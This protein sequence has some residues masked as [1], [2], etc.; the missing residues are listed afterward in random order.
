[1]NDTAID[2]SRLQAAFTSRKWQWCFVDQ[3]ELPAD[4]ITAL[5]DRLPHIARESWPQR[6]AWGGIYVNG[7]GV[8]GNCELPLPCKIEYYEP[9]FPL[10]HAA[11]FYPGFSSQQILYHDDQLVIAFKPI[12]IP[13]LPA[14]EQAHFNF[15]AQLEEYL[16]FRIHLP[17]RLDMSACGLLIASTDSRYHAA[18]NRLYETRSIKKYYRL[19]VSPRVCWAER[20]VDLAIAKDPIHPVLRRTVESGGK[21]ALTHFSLLQHRE[22]TSLLEARPLTGRT[23]QIR[24]HAKQIGHP[25][26]GDKFYSGADASELHLA[27]VRLAFTHPVKNIP[28]DLHLPPRFLPKWAQ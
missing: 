1:V 9:S 2:I 15:K 7:R 24:V 23:H 28:I 6:F 17:A 22:E 3:D 20:E 8:N 18:I 12:G 25:L 4:L 13:S 10:E 19:E 27:C 26:V 21:S 14:R 16:G 5:Q 11:R